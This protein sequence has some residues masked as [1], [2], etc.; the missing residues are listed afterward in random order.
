MG[1]RSP[2][3][4]LRELER[5]RSAADDPARLLALVAEIARDIAEWPLAREESKGLVPGTEEAEE[6]RA[7]ATI[8]TTLERLGALAGLEPGPGELI[9]SLRALTMPLWRGPAEGRVRI[10][11][12][13]RLR[14]GRFGDLFVASLQ[15]GEFPR[16]GG[17]SP[18][19][20]DEQRAQLGLPARAETEAEERYLFY[21]CLSLPTRELWLSCRI[22]DESGGSEQPSPLLARGPPAARPAAP[23]RSR[24][25]RTR[26]RRSWSVPAISTRSPS[27]R[28][29]AP[30][31]VELARSLALC[32]AAE[33]E[34]DPRGPR[35]RAGGGEADRTRLAAASERGPADPGAG[36]AARPGGPRRARLA[37]DEYGATTLE[38]FSVCSYRWFIGEELRP[39]PLGPAAEPLVQG[40]LMHGALEQLYR[41]RPGE[42]PGPAAGLA[43][44]WIER[45]LEL[46]A[47]V[48]AEREL[49]GR[50]RPS[51]RCGGGSGACSSPSFAARLTATRCCSSPSCSRRD[52][53]GRE[54]ATRRPRSRRSTSASG[55]FTG[56]STGSTSAARPAGARAG[57]LQDYKLTRKVTACANFE[58]EGKLPAPPLPDRPARPLGDRADRRRSISR[59]NPPTT[60][61]RA[62]WCCEGPPELEGFG[63]VDNDRLT[64]EDFSK[65][66]EQAAQTASDAV[67]PDALRLDRP[68]PD[69]GRV[70]A[71]LRLRADLP[72]RA[73]DSR[74]RR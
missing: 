48:A 59:S 52:G 11:S 69:R 19:L 24:R 36:A 7:A 66:L 25:S 10:A 20:S 38:A 32:P 70:P 8:A 55:R 68:R 22:S 47:E 31:E 29:S 4:E 41:E 63:L 3:R 50:E 67:A 30:S 49:A 21:S 62:A 6:L 73:R 28:L 13:Y 74:A 35:D 58:K 65:Q 51:G 44:L 54:T 64:A 37:G 40:G 34:G 46:V 56:R 23:R 71:L 12:P 57:L 60:R 43:S 2:E 9:D 16:R 53:A 39:E 27:I 42:R 15:D 33:R 1:A 5:L 18:F 45:G 61:G 17:G 14:A 26:S 72:A